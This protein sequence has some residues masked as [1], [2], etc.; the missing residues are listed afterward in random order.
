MQFESLATALLVRNDGNIPAS[1]LLSVSLRA[2]ADNVADTGDAPL[3]TLTRRVR[4]RPNGPRLLNLR[5][6]LPPGLAAGTYH[7]VAEIDS[8]GSFIE[9]DETDNTA[10][11]AGTFTVV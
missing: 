11:S 5:F 9:S 4:L 3:I 1:G 2:S 7:L 6:L 8:S 10:V